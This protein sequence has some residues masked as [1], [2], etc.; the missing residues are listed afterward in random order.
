[1]TSREQRLADTL[2]RLADTLV[3]DFDVVDLFYRLIDA[4][5]DVA[6]ADAAGLVLSSTEGELSVMAVSGED[7]AL[8]E[9]LQMQQ[10]Q[11]PCF[12]AF[13]TGE[14][15]AAD[16]TTEESRRR[17]PAASAAALEAGYQAVLSIPMRLRDH[18]IG[19]L[20]LF[21][22]TPS[23]LRD[24]DEAAA[25]ALADIATIAILQSRIS[26]DSDVVIGQLQSALESRVVIEQAKGI[27][28]EKTQASMETAFARLRKHAR[29]HNVPL[30]HAADQIV[31]GTLDPDRLPPT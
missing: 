31:V 1:M 22:T 17:W 30:R 5:T 10:Q 20:N 18:V 12:D 15:I 27:I 19:S 9:M 11:G 13:E 2:V 21:M 8:I 29:D 26:H 4:S 23:G 3:K 7:A 16:L 6:G 14:A 24:F 25:Q 28:A